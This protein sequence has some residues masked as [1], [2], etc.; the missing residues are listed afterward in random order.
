[1]RAAR[2][3]LTRSVA[4]LAAIG[5]VTAF[6]APPL[7]AQGSTGTLSGTVT[8]TDHDTTYAW[9]ALDGSGASPVTAVAVAALVTDWVTGPDVLP[10]KL[11]SPPY[12]AVIE[13]DPTDN[14]PVDSVA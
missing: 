13:C 11:A 8:D 14:A 9:P 4:P 10:A 7:H 3:F 12:T 1:M 6:V 5:F 2:R